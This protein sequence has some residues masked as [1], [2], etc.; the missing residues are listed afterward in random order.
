M[1]NLFYLTIMA[2]MLALYACNDETLPHNDG[3]MV[4]TCINVY[5]GEMSDVTARAMIENFLPSGANIGVKVF[6][7][8]TGNVFNNYNNIKYTNKGGEFSQ[9]WESTTPVMVGNTSCDVCAYYPYVSGITDFTAIPVTRA[10]QTD[11]LVTSYPASGINNDNPSINLN[12]KHALAYMKFIVKKSNFPGDGVVSNLTFNDN[13]KNQALLNA[14]TGTLHSF[15]TGG[16]LV[17][18]ENKT[19]TDDGA[20]YETFVIPNNESYSMK[21]SI[22]VDG[23]TLSLPG[24]NI[25]LQQGYFYTFTITISSNSASIQNVE[26]EPWL[27]ETMS[28]QTD[29]VAPNLITAGN[30]DNMAISYSIVENGVV[31][32]AVPTM[33]ICSIK[34]VTMKTDGSTTM[35][36]FHNDASGGLEIY[37]YN[38]N[39][40]TTI[41]FNGTELKENVITAT[42]NVTGS[43]AVQT[44]NLISNNSS[45]DKSKVRKIFL[46]GILV[47][48]G[49][50]VNLNEG[51]HTAYFEMEQNVIP[52][53]MFNGVSSMTNISIDGFN[54]IGNNVFEGC[55]SLKG[56]F[57]IPNS[58]TS[59]GNYVFKDC[60]G[61]NE[62]VLP[63]TEA[64][65]GI[66]LFSGCSALTTIAFPNW[67]T[68]IPAYMFSNCSSL[69]SIDLPSNI[70]SIGEYA[71]KDCS[72]LTAINCNNS[73][74]PSIEQ[75]TFT[76]VSSTGTLTM[77]INAMG[78]EDWIS[79]SGGYLNSDGWSINKLSYVVDLNN[80]WRLSTSVSNPDNSLYE[81]VYESFSNYNVNS[82]AAKMTIKTYVAG[83]FT[84]YIR[85]NAEG[86]YD[87]VM[88]SALDVDIDNSTSYSS[89]NVMAHTRSS[90]SSST[91]IGAYKAVTYE[92]PDNEEHTITIVYRKDGSSHS[93]TDRGYI[94]IA[95]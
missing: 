38:V 95:K 1:K 81:G 16:K 60:A 36:Q 33:S 5:T 83:T 76:G 75:N 47:Q 70:A 69:N 27:Y 20:V 45:F 77:S 48:N 37:L 42:Y 34:D 22:T 49:T 10:E 3:E 29:Y 57:T 54:T 89:A 14:E 9:S 94:L 61:L 84:I 51:E 12:M 59:V 11:Y 66:G 68:Q 25:T 35:K 85:S 17:L 73:I 13:F 44:V 18:N 52:D 23:I 74:A 39:A 55:V 90:Q 91:T 31:V 80:Q 65:I 21:G 92:I 72:S 87:Y 50:N 88:A 30:T 58:V 63:S 15:D 79:N 2:V 8:E 67:M 71:F 24:N 46:D 78:Y 19:I 93:G 43:R 41:T 28:A 40:P 7:S 53:Y 82:T 62:V 56:S 32:N 26:I 6:E 86:S 4:E 64:T